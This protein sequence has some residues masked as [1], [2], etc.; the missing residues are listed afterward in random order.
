[1]WNDVDKRTFKTK[2]Y[3]QKLN[4][5]IKYMKKETLQIF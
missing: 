1:M 3:K 2:Q 5:Y 4:V